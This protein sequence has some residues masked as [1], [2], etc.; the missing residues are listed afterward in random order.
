[1]TVYQVGY[2]KGKEFVRVGDTYE[3][4]YEA[5][6]ECVSYLYED[7]STT[8]SRLSTSEISLAD[9]NLGEVLQ[10]IEGSCIMLAPI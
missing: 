8:L 2:W 9:Y 1:M 7:F 4:Q 6:K 3:S 5:Y 10:M